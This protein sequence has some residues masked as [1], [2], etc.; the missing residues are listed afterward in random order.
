[1]DM[2]ETLERL[3]A[4][5]RAVRDMKL[6]LLGLSVPVFYFLSSQRLWYEKL[7]VRANETDDDRRSK[8]FRHCA[9]VG[10][11]YQAVLKRLDSLDTMLSKNPLSTQMAASIENLMNEWRELCDVWTD[12]EEMAPMTVRT[13]EYD[14]GK[15]ESWIQLVQAFQNSPSRNY[16]PDGFL[17]L[18]GN[19]RL[20]EEV[21]IP[22]IRQ[23]YHAEPPLPYSSED[24]ETVISEAISEALH[25]AMYVSIA[26]SKVAEVIT[27]R[28]RRTADVDREPGVTDS[29]NQEFTKLFGKL[30][31]KVND[32]K[33][34]LA[35]IQYIVS[36]YT[37][38]PE[39][40]SETQLW[41][42]KDA[43]ISRASTEAFPGRGGAGIT[44]RMRFDSFLLPSSRRLQLAH[45]GQ[46]V[47]VVGRRRGEGGQ[48]VGH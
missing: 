32:Y 8:H 36:Q 11:A 22:K 41:A 44:Q 6:F 48:L 46:L 20:L 38:L 34:K 10:D 27:E 21:I 47:D 30:E 33:Q 35:A 5:S 37:L 3:D 2:K 42:V 39:V 15:I 25:A 24:D 7:V 1:M 31:E 23:I 43:F 14:S 26:A 19:I 17:I 4:A 9:N 13:V 45:H 28:W 12:L 18:D 40:W 16:L 29:L